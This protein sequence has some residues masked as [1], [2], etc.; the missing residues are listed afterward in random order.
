[1]HSIQHTLSITETSPPNYPFL[2]FPSPILP[3][4]YNLVHQNTTHLKNSN[5]SIRQRPKRSTIPLGARVPTDELVDRY[6][7]LGS[8]VS[9]GLSRLNIVEG[10]AIGGHSLLDGVRGVDSVVG[11]LCGRWGDACRWWEEEC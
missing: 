11:G 7:K 4:R 9:A 10:L 2:P 6:P 8:N 5:T 1:M 3:Q